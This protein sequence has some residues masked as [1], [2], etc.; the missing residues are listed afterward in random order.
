M[1]RPRIAL[2]RLS[3]SST[4]TAAGPVVSVW[5]TTATSGKGRPLTACQ[6]LRDERATLVGQLVGLET[7]EQDEVLRRPA[8][9]PTARRQRSAARRPR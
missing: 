2:A 1:R 3:P 4:L 7:K 5:P 9:A 8:A 6:D